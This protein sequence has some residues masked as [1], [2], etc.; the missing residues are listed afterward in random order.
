M[1]AS[2]P[3]KQNISE[4]GLDISNDMNVQNRSSFKEQNKSSRYNLN[5]K[6]QVLAQLKS[7]HWFLKPL[8]KRHKITEAPSSNTDILQK[9]TETLIKNEKGESE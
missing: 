4:I 8:V 3:V 5:L 9:F 6:Q 1:E 2:G 7:C